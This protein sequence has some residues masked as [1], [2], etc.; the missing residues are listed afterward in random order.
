MECTELKDMIYDFRPRTGGAQPYQIYDYR[1][2]L[3]KQY[4]K[5]LCLARLS[6]FNTVSVA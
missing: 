4:I 6:S 5:S 1:Q 3:P 2:R